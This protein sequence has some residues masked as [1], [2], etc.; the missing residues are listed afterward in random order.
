VKVQE[1]NIVKIVWLPPEY[2]DAVACISADGLVSLLE[3]IVEG[4]IDSVSSFMSCFV[5]CF[6]FSS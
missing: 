3:E 1:G 6:T 4:I 2:G 5:A